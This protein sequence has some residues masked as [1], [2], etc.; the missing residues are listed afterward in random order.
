MVERRSWPA[1]LYTASGAVPGL[2]IALAA[3]P[4]SSDSA[5]ERFLIGVLVG[6]SAAALLVAS[7]EFVHDRRE[8]HESTRTGRPRPRHP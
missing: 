6:L 5:T 2:L 4:G 8:V 1:W 3:W 7:Y